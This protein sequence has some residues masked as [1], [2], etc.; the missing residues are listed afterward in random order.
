VGEIT[1]VPTFIPLKLLFLL[2]SFSDL[3]RP[4]TTRRKRR[5]NN[6][7]P[8]LSPLFGL[9]TGDATPFIRIAKNQS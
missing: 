3:L 9:K 6:G 7:H 4:S 8:Y 5:G 1:R 2:D